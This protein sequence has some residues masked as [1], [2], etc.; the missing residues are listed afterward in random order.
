MTSE[1]KG[2]LR[3]AFLLTIA[4]MLS[5][6][7]SAGY[8]VPLQNFTGDVGFY[9]YQQIYPLLGMALVL[10][11]YGFPSAISNI[12]AEVKR[13][14]QKLTLNHFYLP[15][16][17]ILFFMVGIIASLLFVFS[18]NVATWVGDPNL[19]RAYK[20]VAVSFL[21]IPFT[22]LLRG[23]SQ[24]HLQMKP[25]AYSQVGEQVVRVFMIILVALYVNAQGVSMY[26]IGEGAA[27]AS[28]FGG[29]VAIFILLIFMKR[30][31]VPRISNERIPWRYYI[32][33]LLLLGFVAA[34]NHMVL[35]LFQ[36]GDAF[37]LIPALQEYGLL[38]REA[39]EEKGV[40]DRG[41]PL[42]Q[43]GTVLGSSFALAMIP[44]ISKSKLQ[45]NPIEF[46]QKVR[47]SLA[48]SFYLAFAA[49]AGLIAIMPEA[50]ILLYQDLKGTVD[51]RILML[52]ILLSAIGITCATIL[53]GLGYMKR[54]A[55]LILVAVMLNWIGNEWLVPIYGITGS[56]I[57]TVIGL[58]F[59]S[60]FVLLELKRKLP[61]L[62]FARYINW[63]ALFLATSAMLLYIFV[64]KQFL[65]AELS[66]AGALF[67]V[68]IIAST[69]ACMYIFILIRGRALKRSE[70]MMLPFSRLLM[71]IYKE[72]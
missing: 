26:R 5:K 60:C 63:R 33:T 8:R 18:G 3:G 45:E 47:S 28:I 38:P 22:S 35:L 52:A 68:G 13:K 15:I 61:N 71:R 64:I 44:S 49:T 21:V 23:A 27:I 41:Q 30:Q 70:I 56:A 37:T 50:N 72:R 39:M 48:I 59:F 62:Q 40:L 46:Y 57:S 65:P 20:I 6:I 17:L 24:G 25:T 2:L 55:L 7:L 42:I 11:L 9:I 34:L 19:T 51:L 14:Q 12:A 58:A 43:L 32:Q 29:I 10:S 4:G 53:Q 16:L 1:S 67:F 54:T 31:E 66:R 36:F 69:G